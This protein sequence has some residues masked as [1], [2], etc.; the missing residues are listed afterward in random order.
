MYEWVEVVSNVGFFVKFTGSVPNH[1]EP[2]S[3]SEHG[4]SGSVGMSGCWASGGAS[5]LA[6]LDKE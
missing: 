4:R 5:V 2:E 6:V 1:M 3:H